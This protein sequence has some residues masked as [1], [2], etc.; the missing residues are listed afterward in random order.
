MSIP[1]ATYPLRL[2]GASPPVLVFI[3][4]LGCSAAGAQSRSQIEA[5]LQQ[6][7][8]R[9]HTLGVRLEQTLNVRD[10][11]L[12]ALRDIELQLIERRQHIARISDK[13]NATQTRQQALEER[14]RR[15][16]TQLQQH[17]QALART[18]RM[19][20]ILEREH[21][22]LWL[23]QQQSPTTISRILGYQSYFSTVKR[24]HIQQARVLVDETNRID[25]VLQRQQA[26]LSA[27]LSAQQQA[28]QAK[29]RE[30]RQR[31]QVLAAINAKL[32]KTTQVRKQLLDEV[33]M[34]HELL[35]G[36][37]AILSDIPDDRLLKRAFIK[38]KG[39]LPWPLGGQLKRSFGTVDSDSLHQQGILLAAPEGATVRAIHHGRVVYANWLLGFGLLL[40]L[41]HG[42][43]YMSL[44][45]HTAR[46]T[47]D[48]GEWVDEGDPIALVGNTGGQQQA[49]LYF[50]I[51]SNGIPS[52]PA[53]WCQ[54]AGLKRIQ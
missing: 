16:I 43:G 30:H 2:W 38:R 12:K 52:D 22:M 20:Y 27:L 23:L 44:Y 48:V 19:V 40:V 53:N 6:L 4:M 24:K 36:I 54:P 35:D 28:Q 8:Q 15:A 42:D 37:D 33:K 11:H 9:I 32:S 34:L 14:R 51:R 29:Q 41:D 3:L 25:R 18:I 49:G 17:R 50:A 10:Q 13:R 21:F 31:Q 1:L 45:G 7:T 26:Q 39:K 47:R 5:D 46:I